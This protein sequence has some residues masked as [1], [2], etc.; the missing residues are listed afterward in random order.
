MLRGIEG[1]I[2]HR[3]AGATYP[4]L[5]YDGR[6]T[7]GESPP[8]PNPLAPFP[9]RKGGNRTLELKVFGL[10]EGS[11]FYRRARKHFSY[12]NGFFRTLLDSPF[13]PAPSGS[14]GFA[15]SG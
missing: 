7:E 1:R 14:R 6:G 15:T 11:Q 9:P 10:K 2:A 8:R 5:P 12:V 4:P 13:G 3:A